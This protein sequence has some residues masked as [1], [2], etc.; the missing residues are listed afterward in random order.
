MNYYWLGAGGGTGKNKI[1]DPD[2]RISRDLRA[3]VDGFANC[4]STALYNLMAGVL[5]TRELYRYFGWRFA[6]APY[7]YLGVASLVVDGLLPMRREWRKLGHMR[8]LTWGLYTNA[9]QR[10][11]LHQEGIAA[12]GGGPRECDNIDFEY[13]ACIV[14][15]SKTYRSWWKFASINNFF[16]INGALWLCMPRAGRHHSP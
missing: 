3:T 14:E 8:G 9:A 7:A 15:Y 2:A 16:M 11:E 5:Y 13:F 10:L 4:F 1:A 12:L 6:V